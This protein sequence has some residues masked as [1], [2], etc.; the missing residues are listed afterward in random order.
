MAAILQ[1]TFSKAVKTD[2]NCILI[3][4]P[5]KLIKFTINEDLFILLYH[6]SPGT[7]ELTHD[8]AGR[9]ATAMH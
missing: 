8:I 5:L 6:A 4:V 7:D 9:V 3:P 2:E 1:V